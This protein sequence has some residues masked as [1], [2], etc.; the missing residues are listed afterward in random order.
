M[1][2]RPWN[3]ILAPSP[4]PVLIKQSNGWP[5]L[6]VESL[7]VDEKPEPPTDESVALSLSM[8]SA[9]RMAGSIE[10]GIVTCIYKSEGEDK[11]LVIL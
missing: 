2:N 9:V 1:I 7:R 3:M 10:D 5:S 8:L 11:C 6:V 4:E